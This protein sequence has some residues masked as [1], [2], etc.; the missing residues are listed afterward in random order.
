M[1]LQYMKEETTYQWRIKWAGKWGTT[2]HN[3]TE[4]Q[5]RK[6]HP[7]A[8]CLPHTKRVLLLPETPEE[9]AARMRETCTSGF[10]DKR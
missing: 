1:L 7:E 8:I 10:L 5:I 3:C 9:V 4:E 6:E 2:R